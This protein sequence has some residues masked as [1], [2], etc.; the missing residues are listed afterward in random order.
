MLQSAEKDHI[1]PERRLQLQLHALSKSI[2]CCVVER[3]CMHLLSSR[4]ITQYENQVIM[5]QGTDMQKA[6]QLLQVVLKK[7]RGACL[8]FYKS[9]ESC[10]PDVYER[11]TGIP[12]VETQ[13]Q[14]ELSEKRNRSSPTYI[15]NISHSNLSNFIVG[16]SSFQHV[17]TCEQP[18]FT[19]DLADLPQ[20]TIEG[21]YRSDHQRAV[22][23]C[24]DP[25]SQRSVQVYGSNLQYVIIGDNNT[26][27][28]GD[29]QEE[30]VDFLEEEP[31][32][33]N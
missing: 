30:D 3:L 10:C 26:M 4:T 12:A 33:S 5:S 11:I 27:L 23:V 6:S 13:D 18:S 16:D 24:T 32:E 25:E 7:G 21:M 14:L 19:Q 1:L 31:T 22:Q 15:I 28:V 20:E 29:T 8:L 2:S 17:T 9:L